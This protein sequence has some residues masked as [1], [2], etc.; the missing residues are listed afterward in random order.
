[1]TKQR[2]VWNEVDRR[3]KVKTGKFEFRNFSELP[4]FGKLM[5]IIKPGETPQP[6]EIPEE[7]RAEL[8]ADLKEL[9]LGGERLETSFEIIEVYD[10][11]LS[12]IVGGMLFPI[13]AHFLDPRIIVRVADGEDYNPLLSE[14][15]LFIKFAS[16]ELK[17]DAILEFINRYG[18]LGGFKWGRFSFKNEEW[19]EPLWWFKSEQEKFKKLYETFKKLKKNPEDRETLQTTLTEGLGNGLKGAF[20]FLPPDEIEEKRH[21]QVKLKDSVALRGWRFNSLL[22]ALY[23]QLYNAVRQEFN[24]AT[25]RYC[26][27]DFIARAGSRWC[28][29]ACRKKLERETTKKKALATTEEL[30]RLKKQIDIDVSLGK[31][32]NTLKAKK[33]KNSGNKLPQEK[34]TR[35]KKPVK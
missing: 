20:A 1:M 25:C 4:L 5:P 3:S 28:S 30:K 15:E 18:N 13:M 35:A 22:P 7:L 24:I 19:C 27:R 11:L 12:F 2:D 9:K 8:E 26:K 32:Q 21:G 14:S 33:L 23:F 17:D 10:I 6:E 34:G 16:L 31:K 29:D